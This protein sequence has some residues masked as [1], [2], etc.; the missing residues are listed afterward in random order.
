MITARSISKELSCSVS[1]L[2]TAYNSMDEILQDV[3][4]ECTRNLNKY[5]SE[6]SEYRLSFKEMGLRLYRFSIEEPKLFRAL[7]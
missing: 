5:L 7:F 1:P 4:A 3:L 2:F 6:V